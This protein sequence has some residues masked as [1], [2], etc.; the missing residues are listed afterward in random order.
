MERELKRLKQEEIP[1]AME[2]LRRWFVN[3][4]NYEEGISLLEGLAVTGGGRLLAKILYNLSEPHLDMICRT[5]AKISAVCVNFHLKKRFYTSALYVFGDGSDGR[6]G[7]DM[8]FDQKYPFKLP[9]LPHIEMVSCAYGGNTAV[10]TRDGDLYTFGYGE[11]G[12]L[13]N[14]KTQTVRIPQK[15]Q[16]LPPIKMVSCGENHTAIVDRNGNLYTFGS[17]RKGQLGDGNSGKNYFVS[18]P[19]R[20]QN[21]PPIEMVACGSEHTVILTKDGDVY[22]FGSC[23][24]GKLGNGN[25][26]YRINVTIP[27]KIENL[28]PMKM[29]SCSQHHTAIVSRTGDLYTF[30]SCFF[31]KLGN[32]VTHNAIV[33]EPKLIDNLRPVKM[34]S[35]GLTHTAVV[36]ENGDLYMFGDGRTGALGDGITAETSDKRKVGIPQKVKG[37][38]FIIS[39][40]CGLQYTAII[41]QNGELYTFGNCSYGRLGNGISDYRQNVSI[42]QKIPNIPP[43]KM[44][45]CGYSHTAFVTRSD[46]DLGFEKILLPCSVCIGRE[47]TYFSIEDKKAY[48]GN[49]IY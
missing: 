29:V 33:S 2:I 31:G 37:I 22:T 7:K 39:A 10:V 24:N 38:P 26:D 17:G 21:I 4:D 25:I 11:D 41:S 9:D 27:Q 49:E 40:S 19:Q 20:I 47:A 35:C 16:G 36:C 34:V 42:P 13:G 14:G 18:R 44:V 23:E 43:V 28:P 6:L 8:T 1:I 30:G 3:I 12:Q 48:C 32:G 46:D 15:I 5:S 45:S